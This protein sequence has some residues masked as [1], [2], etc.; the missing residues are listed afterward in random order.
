MLQTSSVMPCLHLARLPH[1]LLAAVFTAPKPPA[2]AQ[3][4]GPEHLAKALPFSWVRPS[5]RAVERP[6]PCMDA[7]GNIHGLF[8]GNSDGHGAST[9]DEWLDKFWVQVCRV[10]ELMCQ[11]DD[12]QPAL[13]AG[14]T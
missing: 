13:N 4:P 11:M 9:F 8:E 2:C 14:H 5:M 12:V 6:P 1:G 3:V 7:D 10:R